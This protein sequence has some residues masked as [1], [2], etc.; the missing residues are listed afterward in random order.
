M[1]CC[2]RSTRSPKS[3]RCGPTTCRPR[4]RPLAELRLR[5]EVPVRG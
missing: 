1:R 3:R 2:G 5:S 4:P